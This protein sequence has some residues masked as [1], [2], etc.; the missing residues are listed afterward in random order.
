MIIR[1]YPQTT[2]T[3][4]YELQKKKLKTYPKD[5][6]LAEK[7]NNL[8]IRKLQVDYDKW[9]RGINYKTGR[10]IKIGG[11]LHNALK[12]VFMI[13]KVL[14]NN[15]KIISSEDIINIK[16][17]ID[18]ENL[19]ITEFNLNI[20]KK[21]EE[22]ENNNNIINDFINKLDKL[23]KWNYYL[24]FNGQKFGTKHKIINKIHIENSCNGEMIFLK[25]IHLMCSDCRVDEITGGHGYQRYCDCIYK[26]IY[27][28]NICGYECDL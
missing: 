28:C 10:T 24:E 16:K 19:K 25:E 23:D 3:Y 20:D 5:I 8:D 1:D 26:Y 18:S 22:T 11:K 14:F 15:I 6:L 9:E 12:K 17:E 2:N 27:E 7:L 13:D 21:I 4:V